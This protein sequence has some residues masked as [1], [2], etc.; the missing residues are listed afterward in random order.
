LDSLRPH[1]AY[2]EAACRA[3]GAAPL[4]RRKAMLAAALI[5][6]YVD[7]LFAADDTVDDILAYRESVAAAQPALG[8]VMALCAGR[9]GVGVAIEAVGVPLADY[10]ALPVEDFMVS[11]YNDH[12]VQ[13]LRLTLPDGGRLDMQ[14]VLREALA[15]LD[16]LQT[17]RGPRRVRPVR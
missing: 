12:S 14:D 11:L 4:S 15:G 10:G 3:A 13:R 1:R 17:R 6:A 16:A 7:R 8:L 2:L 9:A 5:D